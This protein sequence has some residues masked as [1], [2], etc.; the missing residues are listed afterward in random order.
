MSRKKNI[1]F[2]IPSL[3]GGGAERTLINLLKKIDYER[4]DVD[5][6]VVSKMGPYVQEV[7]S[8]VNTTYLYK[9]NFIVRCLAY[10][11]REYGIDWFFK[12]KMEKV[13]TM[14]DVGISFIDSNFTDLLF[15][16][17]NVKRRVAIIHSSY[18]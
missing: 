3:R 12:N 5:L 18:L 17:E 7:P 9:N 1:L 15:L 6:L 11:H 13:T 16:K 10:L 4:Y 8:D 2:L 14:Y